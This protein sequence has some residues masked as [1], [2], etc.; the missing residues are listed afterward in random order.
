M[1]SDVLI[2]AVALEPSGKICLNLNY[3]A[4]RTWNQKCPPVG[5]PVPFQP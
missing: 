5:T 1:K 3:I 2:T 4:L